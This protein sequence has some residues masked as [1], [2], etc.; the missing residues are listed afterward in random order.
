MVKRG[1]EKVRRKLHMKYDQLHFTTEPNR[2][3]EKE[4]EE[5]VPPPSFPPHPR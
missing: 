2:G 1:V 4:E 3:G 5:L